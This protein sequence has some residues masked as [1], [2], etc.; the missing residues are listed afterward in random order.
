MYQGKKRYPKDP[1][2]PA[3]TCENPMDVV[4]ANKSTTM[5]DSECNR[6]PACPFWEKSTAKCCYFNARGVCTSVE[7]TQKRCW[8]ISRAHWSVHN[9][10]PT[11]RTKPMQLLSDQPS[12]LARAQYVSYRSHKTNANVEL[13]AELTG[14]CTILFLQIAQ[15]QCKCWVISRSH[16]NMHNCCPTNCTKP[17][18]ACKNPVF[19]METNRATCSCFSGE[20]CVRLFFGIVVC[21]AWRRSTRWCLNKTHFLRTFQNKCALVFWHT[22]RECD[23]AC[24]DEWCWT[25]TSCPGLM[26][27]C[28]TETVHQWYFF[29]RNIVQATLKSMYFHYV[30]KSCLDSI[31]QKNILLDFE[32]RSTA[33][34]RA[35]EWTAGVM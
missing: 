6:S 17:K 28:R 8:A 23:V 19:G 27:A 11:D 31:T 12:S 30:N 34:Q 5:S 33:V 29:G 1:T 20:V 15:N 24:A 26:T 2:K 22:R 14:A 18:P 13:S 10:C 21:T 25:S 32:N 7:I 9:T 3:H 4:L 35:V 16:W